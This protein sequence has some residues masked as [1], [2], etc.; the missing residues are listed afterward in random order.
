VNWFPQIGSGSL[1]QLP[2]H[3]RR[4]WRAI[5]NV[6]EEGGSI[7][8]ADP[9]SGEIEWRLSYR[10]LS[11]AEVSSLKELFM[12]CRGRFE[13]FGFADP[14][15]NLLAW[16]EDLTRP[17]WQG[18]LIAVAR[19]VADPQGGQGASTLS[20]GSAGGQLVSQ[21]MDVPGQYVGCFSVWMRSDVSRSI[22]LQRDGAAAVAEVNP[23]WKRF[24]VSGSGGPA[25]ANSSVSLL[26]GPG[27]S[28]DVWGQ[29][30]EAQPYP[31]QYKP[32]KGASRIYPET[33]FGADELTITSVG[34]GRS[35]CEMTL[36]S[37]V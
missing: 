30:F 25:A 20:N 22:T 10:D 11:E 19:G 21:T 28:V 14:V 34:V 15:A 18:G 4:K 24:F 6:M 26:V 12:A 13:A 17:N 8:L 2:L 3:R 31:S 1:V 9:A 32:T 16:S 27:Q 23:Q 35:S 33:Y 29:Q 37:R 7:S 5:T 36:V